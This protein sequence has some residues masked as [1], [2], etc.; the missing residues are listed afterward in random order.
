MVGLLRARAP[1][2]DVRR[3][4]S[5]IYLVATREPLEKLIAS[6]ADPDHFR[7]YFG[8]A[9]WAPGQL[10]HEVVEG[11]WHVAPADAALVFDPDPSSVWRREIRLTEG[12]MALR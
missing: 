8:S 1:G 12:L 2:Q 10:E 5:D 4:V 3:V 11:A 7:V 9:G 6:G